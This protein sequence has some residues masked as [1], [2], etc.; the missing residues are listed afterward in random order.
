MMIKT[1]EIR[2]SF[3]DYFKENDHKLIPSSPVIPY[4]DPTLLFINA[5]MCQF[6]DIFT[7]NR[8]ID[9]SRAT[10]CQ[11]CLR[12]GGKHNDLD[13]VG[14][15]A[16]HHTFFEM[17]GN[18]S[19]G[20][21]FK[22][23]TIYYA[24]EYFTKTLKL[25]VDKLYVSVFETDDDA[26][27]LWA[28]IA[29][30][31]KNGRILRFGE[32]DNFWSM[33]ETG[34]CGPSSEIHYDRGEKYGTG[35]EDVVNGESDRVIEIW[36]LVFMQ[37]DRQPDGKLLPL[38]KPSIDTGA[39]LERLAS[40]LQGVDS[41]FEI[42]LF[43]DLISAISDISKTKYSDHVSSHHV[44]ADHL[45][46]LTFAISDGAGISNEGQGYV[47]RRILRRAARHGRLLGMQEPFIYRLVP[48]LVDLM[49]EAYPELEAKKQ[50]VEI[51]IKNEEE[52]FGRTLDTGLELFETIAIDTESRGK[53]IVGGE[54]VFKLYDTYGFPYDLTEI[55]A[56]ERGLTLDQVGFDGAMEKQKKQSRMVAS[57]AIPVEF[58][59]ILSDKAIQDLPATE[60]IRD[61]V[62]ASAKVL[63]Y[64]K[65]QKD[66]KD[67]DTHII[68]LD[69]T[70]FYVESGGQ[71]SD[72][73]TICGDGFELRV[74]KLAAHKNLIVHYAGLAKGS[75]ESLA[76]IKDSEVRVQIDI[77]RRRAI[78]R[79][80]TATHLAH[81]ALRKVL[82]EHVSQKGSYVGPDRL[83]FDFS[84]HQPMT[85]EEIDKVE[86]IVNEQ[87]LAAS[88]VNT[89]IMDIGSARKSGAMALF[90]EKYD[91]K[92]RV[93]S[94]SGFSKEL[95]GGTH[96][97]NVSEIGLFMLTVETGIASG[98]RRLEAITGGEAIAQARQ[99]R[100]FRRE[101]ASLVGRPEDDALEAVRHLKDRSN[102]AAKEI[103]KLKEEMFASGSKTI[104]ERKKIGGVA[105]VTHDF[106]ESDRDS[107]GAWLDTQK[108]LTEPVFALAYGLVNGK[109]MCLVSASRSAV[110][111]HSIH[112]GNWMKE[113]LP[114]LG[115]RGGG[116]ANFAQGSV[117]LGTLWKSVKEKAELIV[118]EGK[119]E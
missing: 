39:G 96:V 90:G 49:G 14:F 112:V 37:Y 3:L 63:F 15:N 27:N 5:G 80:H 26:Y 95:C 43:V 1:S 45:R 35:P 46:A 58:S 92:V 114:S 9:Y 102:A 30:E 105:I 93:V 57:F 74:D 47:L 50:H 7:G 48:L 115:G 11:K 83:R 44:I 16:R 62:F 81:A 72:E 24:W 12:V 28:K 66:S 55:L 61:E 77:A 91:E 71:I 56:T 110:K 86:S 17:L 82:G 19:F 32:K 104:G 31:L 67:E 109:Q 89:E 60:F 87:I 107:M 119:N 118:S 42:D 6:K 25:P 38:P 108:N 40:V 78:M 116:K 76:N 4:D 51:V 75:I 70:P 59:N 53:N 23:E 33:G 101:V 97:E 21:Y 88:K 103:K 73:G 10:S 20:D 68:I 85:L 52:S 29:P 8:Q 84:H 2:Q 69:R 100:S 22:E 36:N 65:V 99:A 41:N 117:A 54:N 111:N 34:P 79:N 13:N 113:Q 106:G 64:K 98:V 18:F 94:V